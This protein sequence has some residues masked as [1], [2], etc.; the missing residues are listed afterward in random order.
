M[1]I[2]CSS[3]AFISIADNDVL[4]SDTFLLAIPNLVSS[5]VIISLVTYSGFFPLLKSL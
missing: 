1:G 2:L 3:S 5:G 4:K